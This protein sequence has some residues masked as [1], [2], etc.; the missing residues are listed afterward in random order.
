MKISAAGKKAQGHGGGGG[1]DPGTFHAPFP[2][3][4][5]RFFPFVTRLC[6]PRQRDRNRRAEIPQG[7]SLCAFEG[8]REI[9]AAETEEILN[10]ETVGRRTTD[11]PLFHDRPTPTPTPL[12]FS[13]SPL[14]SGTTIKRPPRRSACI[15]TRN[16]RCCCSRGL[17]AILS[18]RSRA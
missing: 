3:F 4:F 10:S 13:A 2:P 7:C 18:R 8:P 6:P 15:C 17:E 11:L 5:L 16:G 12:P 9:S 14:P 1:G